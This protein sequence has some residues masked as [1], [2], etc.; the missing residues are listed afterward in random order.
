[1]IWTRPMTSVE[2]RRYQVEQL[3]DQQVKI[4]NVTGRFLIR[5]VG[6]SLADI[7]FPVW[8]I[9]EPTPTFGSILA[10]GSALVRDSFPILSAT[11]V[12]WHMHKVDDIRSYFVG[13][14]I[15]CYTAGPESLRLYC[16][17]S[18][19]AKALRNPSNRPDLG[20]DDSI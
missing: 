5:G 7:E 3:R 18:M 20:M 4:T 12:R 16:T 11:V 15:A 1:M 2:K 17:Y 19:E 6:E 14:Q 8:F 13:A 10:P 9:E